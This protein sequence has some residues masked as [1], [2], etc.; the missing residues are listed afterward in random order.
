[1]CLVHVGIK[2]ISNKHTKPK[3]IL[4]NQ[5]TKVD[6]AFCFFDILNDMMSIA[7]NDER[8]VPFEEWM[9]SHANLATLQTKMKKRNTYK[10]TEIGCNGQ[11]VPNPVMPPGY[12]S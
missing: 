1:M 5:R 6:D 3:F 8:I 12:S 2:D 4:S 7:I 10:R 11:W 9:L